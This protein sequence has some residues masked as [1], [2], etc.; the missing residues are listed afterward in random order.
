MPSE[1]VSS[2]TLIYTC[3]KRIASLQYYSVDIGMHILQSILHV[4]Q[5]GTGYLLMLVAM[6]FNVWLFLSVILGFGAGYFF[7]GR[8]RYLFSENFRETNE[9]C[10]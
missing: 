6:T 8:M 4:I 3:S 10:N 2:S 9:C 1:T 5:I 7:F